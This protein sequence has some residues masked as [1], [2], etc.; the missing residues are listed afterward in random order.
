MKK[1]L[2]SLLATVCMMLVLRWQG[3]SLITPSSPYGI[4]S[5]ELAHTY[6]EA[7]SVIQAA[8]PQVLQSNIWLDFLF[9]IAYTFFLFYSIRL[10]QKDNSAR[11]SFLLRSTL[12]PGL[13]DM[14]ENTLM[15]LAIARPQPDIVILLTRYTAIAK[16]AIAGLL[17]LY[18][19]VTALLRL[20]FAKKTNG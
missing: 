14:L 6:E 16:F 12:L 3:Q 2:V 5:L 20:I 18:I 13:L 9:I 19:I 1:F 7:A 15:L 4:L 8:G 11:P 17:L 10:L